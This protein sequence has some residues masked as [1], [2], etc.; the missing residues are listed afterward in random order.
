M[1]C[2][3]QYDAVSSTPNHGQESNS[4]SGDVIVMH[5]KGR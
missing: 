2:P 4:L 3:L 1:P 5:C